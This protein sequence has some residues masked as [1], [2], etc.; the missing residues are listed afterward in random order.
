MFQIKTYSYNTF[1]NVQNFSLV[2]F[3]W[4]RRWIEASALC[5]K[6]GN[7]S[8]LSLELKSW[9]SVFYDWQTIHYSS[10]FVT[11]CSCLYVSIGIRLVK[12]VFFI[13]GCTLRKK[14]A[15]FFF[16]QSCHLLVTKVKYIFFVNNHLI[17]WWLN[18]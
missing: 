8:V 4:K 11:T 18:I 12:N 3:C 13:N 9:F 5:G 17:F 6:N 1:S 15:S 14:S 10:P 16:R 2:T 7:L